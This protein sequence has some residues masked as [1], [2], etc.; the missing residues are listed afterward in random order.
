MRRT[1]GYKMI[2]F[3]FMKLKIFEAGSCNNASKRMTDKANLVFFDFHR[4]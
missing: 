4:I 3:A 1:D 2:K